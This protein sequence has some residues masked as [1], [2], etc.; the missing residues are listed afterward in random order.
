MFI[1]L[2][3]FILVENYY[4]KYENNAC[5]LKLGREAH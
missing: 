5:I 4:I 2:F 1:A 3:Y